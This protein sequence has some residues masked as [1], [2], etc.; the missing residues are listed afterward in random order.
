M[1]DAGITVVLTNYST[2]LNLHT[3]E[4]NNCTIDNYIVLN[5]KYLCTINLVYRHVF[6]KFTPYIPNK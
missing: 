6:T 1:L 5:Y 3:H 4:S 2:I